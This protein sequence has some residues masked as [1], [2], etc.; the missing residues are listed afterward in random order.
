MNNDLLIKDFI[1]LFKNAKKIDEKNLS[2]VIEADQKYLTILQ[3]FE[4]QDS[5]IFSSITQDGKSFMFDIAQ[6]DKSKDIEIQFS[7][8][9]I[10][11]LTGYDI[12]ATFEDFIKNNTTKVPDKFLILKDFIT[13]KSD[14]NSLNIYKIIILLQDIFKD[15]SDNVEID[16]NKAIYTFF[17]AKKIQ[18]NSKFNTEDIDFISEHCKNF[19]I[20]IKK[21][22]DDLEL[23]HQKQLRTVFFKK[24]LESIFTNTNL[25]MSDILQNLQQILQEYEAHYRAYINSLEPEKI[26]AEFEEEHYKVLKELNSILSDV[27]NKIIFIPIAFIFGGAQLTSGD[28]IK[29]SM[30]IIGMLVFSSFVSLFLETHSKVLTILKNDID[31]KQSFYKK[32]NPSLFQKFENKMKSLQELHDNIVTRISIV[33]YLNWILT[34]TATFIFLAKYK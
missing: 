21:L 12:Y 28:Y 14:C 15:I 6:I 25:S 3:K 2:I 8:R 7:Q 30:I 24:S 19:G 22:Y 16:N 26:K 32:E 9:D 27:H 31:E 33:K 18:I 20:N 23:E 11:R 1:T 13:D 5:I 29:A 17:D 34:L 10:K 4:E